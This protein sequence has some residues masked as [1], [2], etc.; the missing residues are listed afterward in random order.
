MI[1]SRRLWINDTTTPE[2][3][4]FWEYA[5][6]LKFVIA[7]E[8]D[9]SLNQEQMEAIEEARI[10]LK[11]NGGKSHEEVMNKMKA[12]FPKAFRA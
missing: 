5:K 11:K 8:E 1:I 10:S 4:A 3:I 9:I 2:A 6:K 7:E 12:K